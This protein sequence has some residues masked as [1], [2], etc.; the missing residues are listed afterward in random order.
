[1]ATTSIAVGLKAQSP[2]AVV[3]PKH[4][5]L[6]SRYENVARLARLQGTVTV[7][8]TVSGEG[9]VIAA[10][11]SSTDGLLKE[12]PILQ[13]KT[14]ELTRR[15]KFTCPNCSKDGEY[16]YNVT[17]I[18]KLEGKETSYNDTQIAV[19]LPDQ[20]TIKANPPMIEAD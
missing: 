14:A 2:A 1:L 18:Y 19:D 20:V 15:W 16:Q 6:P 10:E 5:E 4:L 3:T 8:L 11:P 13:A 12:H 9:D 17:F 7:R